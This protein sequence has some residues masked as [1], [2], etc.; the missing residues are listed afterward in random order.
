MSVTAARVARRAPVEV[1]LHRG[2]EVGIRERQEAVEVDVRRADVVDQ[3]VDLAVA[4]DR[5]RDQPARA[6]GV[7]Q[8]D[9]QRGDVLEP[10]QRADRARAGDDE[11]ALGDELL[12]DRQADALARS[13]DD[14]DA[15]GQFK[16]HRRSSRS[17]R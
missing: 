1:D 3:H 10:F 11:R 13:G 12:D 17:I 2:L 9:R 7:G 4:L 5:M 8:I 16:V 6:F 14:G 15:V